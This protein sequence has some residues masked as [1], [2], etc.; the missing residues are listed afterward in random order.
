MDL[1]INFSFLQSLSGRAS[2]FNERII[3][4]FSPSISFFPPINYFLFILSIWQKVET[5]NPQKKV[6]NLIIVVVAWMLSSMK[7]Q[8]VGVSAEAAATHCKGV[9]HR[10]VSWTCVCSCLNTHQVELGTSPQLKFNSDPLNVL[11][12]F[13]IFQQSLNSRFLRIASDVCKD[14]LAVAIFIRCTFSAWAYPWDIRD[15]SPVSCSF[16]FFALDWRIHLSS[17]VSYFHLY[18]C[19]WL[20]T[21]APDFSMNQVSPISLRHWNMPHLLPAGLAGWSQKEMLVCFY[22]LSSFSDDVLG[23]S[24]TL[25]LSLS[26]LFVFAVELLCVC[27]WSY[28]IRQVRV[29]RG[30]PR[31]QTWASDLDALSPQPR[32]PLSDCGKIS[33]H[34][35]PMLELRRWVC[36]SESSDSL[37]FLETS[38]DCSWS[39]PSCLMLFWLRRMGHVWLSWCRFY[40]LILFVFS[41]RIITI[42]SA[43]QKSW[44]PSF[45]H[46]LLPKTQTF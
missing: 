42:Y 46:V 19:V 41:F 24:Y 7:E 3:T 36:F 26:L 5:G 25:S 10:N 15:S 37:L 6:E 29:M 28:C 38:W 22:F 32:N 43:V 21:F 20:R 27:E 35:R 30:R 1:F 44:H 12:S 31:V 17:S 8:G 45:L 18:A 16:C 11:N 33:L 4:F 34:R 13:L 23:V 39:P 2:N 40:L 9:F 14:I